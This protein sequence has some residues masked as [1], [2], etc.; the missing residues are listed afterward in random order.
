MD[1]ITNKPAQDE[2]GNLSAGIGDPAYIIGV[3]VEQYRKQY[4]FLAPK[5][6]AEDYVSIV[7]PIGTEVTLDG[8]ELGQDE[9]KPF[10]DGKYAVSYQRID[11]GRHELKAS[12]P[13]GLFSYGVDQYVSYGYPAGLDLRELFADD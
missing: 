10:G 6:Y 3:P 4:T 8:R 1:F 5:F 7:A 9:F 13:V 11:D 2:T 12:R